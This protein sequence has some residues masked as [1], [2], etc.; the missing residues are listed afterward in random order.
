MANPYHPLDP[1]RHQRNSRAVSSPYENQGLPTLEDYEKLVLAYQ[2][3]QNRFEVQGRQ[4]Q[5][6]TKQYRAKEQEVQIRDDVLK[7]QSEDIKKIDSEL[8]WTKAAL[9]QAESTVQELQQAKQEEA[10]EKTGTNWQEKYEALQQEVENLRKRWEQRYA[11]SVAEARNQI[12]LDMLPLADHLDLALQHASTI[13]NEAIKAF[14]ENIESTQRAF[15]DTLRRYGVE[16]LDALGKPFD[17][18]LHEAIGHV[19]MA[20]VPVNHVAQVVQRGY[21]DGER[22]LRPARVVVSAGDN[23]DAQ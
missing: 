19:A 2:D 4:V 1:R 6:L 8:L 21:M 12:L 22:L 10:T 18:N 15:M 3:L 7:R 13:E 14:A 17:P 9:Q 11:Q 16:R 23:V 20:D 5:E